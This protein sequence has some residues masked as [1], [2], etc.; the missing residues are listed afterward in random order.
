MPEN[1]R[2]QYGRARCLRQL[3][4][5]REAEEG[6]RKTMELDPSDPGPVN[7]LARLL[8]ESGRAEEAQQMFQKSAELSKKQ[9]SAAPGEIRYE[10]SKPE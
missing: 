1:A 10:S 6:L 8:L 4:K 9:R 5:N 7:A 3:G 2:A